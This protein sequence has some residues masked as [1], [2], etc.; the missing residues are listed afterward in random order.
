MC[1]NPHYLKIFHGNKT[2]ALPEL[3][4][5]YPDDTEMQGGI[6]DFLVSFHRSPVQ[7]CWLQYSGP[8]HNRALRHGIELD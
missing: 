6:R 2:T 3:K 7:I 5:L 8:L 1:P 4:E